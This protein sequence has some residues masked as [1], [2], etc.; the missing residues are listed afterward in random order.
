MVF[1]RTPE[2]GSPLSA[3]S[4]DLDRVIAEHSEPESS[5]EDVSH[6]NLN[7]LS[8]VSAD[9]SPSVFGSLLLDFICHISMM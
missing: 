6:S 4:D 7:Q 2:L 8:S 3:Q 9:F 5:S 1:T